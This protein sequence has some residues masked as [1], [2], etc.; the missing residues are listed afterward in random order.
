MAHEV[1]AAVLRRGPRVLLCRRSPGRA[2]FPGVWDLP[3][4]HVEPGESPARALVRELAEEIGVR[5]PPPTAGP[6]TRVVDPGFDLSVW[7]VDSW[8]GE[9]AILDRAEHD[10]LRWCSAAD[11]DGLEVADE[12]LRAV[13]RRA[14]DAVSAPPAR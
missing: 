10:R 3:G 6:W 2:W 7:L 5:V 4:G 12:R 14:I 8:R 1:V 13:L 9:P 11:L